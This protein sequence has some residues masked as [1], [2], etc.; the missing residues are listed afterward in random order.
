MRVLL[1][2]PQWKYNGGMS[3]R[4]IP[5]EAGFIYDQEA[6]PKGPNGRNLCRQCSEE[7]S[8]GRRTFCSEACVHD[9]K[10]RTDPTY[11][12]QQ[13]LKRDKGICV[14]CGRDCVADQEELKKALLRC[15][16][17][18][19][20]YDRSTHR[21]VRIS[22]EMRKEAEE[23]VASIREEYSAHRSRTTLWDMEHSKPVVEGGGECGLDNLLTCCIPCHKARTKAL[24]AKRA[25]ERREKA[26]LASDPLADRREED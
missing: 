9:W 14:D 1:F 16:H 17:Y 2:S 4:R 12:K 15:E 24:A 22:P 8:A 21:Y 3:T 10:C 25:R 26:R 23:K 5:E 7:V 20:Y 6:L 11:Q 13:V 18:Y 19:Q